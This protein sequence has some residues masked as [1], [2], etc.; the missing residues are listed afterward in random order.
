MPSSS[1]RIA[2]VD[3]LSLSRRSP[4][5]VAMGASSFGLF[6]WDSVL[7]FCR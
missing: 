6:A 7:W 4:S 5:M 2:M 1:E 3:K